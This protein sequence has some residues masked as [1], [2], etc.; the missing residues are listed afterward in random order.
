MNEFYE[1]WLIGLV[2]GSMVD[3]NEARTWA[4]RMKRERDE[5][6]RTVQVLRVSRAHWREE[7]ER[8]AGEN[9]ELVEANEQITSWRID[10]MREKLLLLE[11]LKEIGENDYVPVSVLQIIDRALAKVEANDG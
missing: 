5:L 3:T 7:F 1:H 8:V 11:A 10:V 9:T 2:N 6:K 4:R